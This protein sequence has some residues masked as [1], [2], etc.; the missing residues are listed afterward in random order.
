M[1]TKLT[2][3]IDKDLVTIARDVANNDGTSVSALFSDY[4]VSRKMRLTVSTR[5]SIDSMIGSLKAYTIDDSKDGIKSAYVQ[6]YLN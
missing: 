2:L 1:K 5:S 4:I 6:K 3:S